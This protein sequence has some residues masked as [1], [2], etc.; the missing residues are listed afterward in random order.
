M[1]RSSRQRSCWGTEFFVGV[2]VGSLYIIHDE[3]V[4]FHELGEG[5]AEDWGEAPVPGH[6]L[7]LEVPITS[8]LIVDERHKHKLVP[9]V[10]S[11]APD[12]DIH[13]LYYRLDM[14]VERSRSPPMWDFV[15]CES[16]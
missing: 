4:V 13:V 11:S 10:H 6:V 15:P 14:F 1:S 16:S 8:E 12:L 9:Q 5:L 7:V 2:G 3:S